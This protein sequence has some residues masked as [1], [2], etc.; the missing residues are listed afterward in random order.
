MKIKGIIDEDFTNYKKAS[1]FIA[2]PHCTF[3]CEQECGLHCCQ[4]KD[5]IDEPNIELSEFAI[6]SRYSFNMITNAI[7]IGGLEPF[8]D[9]NDLETLV[10]ALRS[11]TQDD[12]VIYS[13]YNED[14]IKDKLRI[15]C[16]YKNIIV[17]FGRFVPNSALRYDEVLGVILASDNQYARR[18]S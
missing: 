13:G 3:K 10:N 14:E 9:W 12:I 15:L 2:F 11:V 17:K 7:V 1:M 6:A 4:N 5:L 18:I 8:D 16:R